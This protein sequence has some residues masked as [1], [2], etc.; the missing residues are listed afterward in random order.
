MED[1]HSESWIRSSYFIL[2]LDAHGQGWPSL[3]LDDDSTRRED[4]IS[5]TWSDMDI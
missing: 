1:N 2:F 3:T 4:G 5:S